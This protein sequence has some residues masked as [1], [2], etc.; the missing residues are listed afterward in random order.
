M[1]ARSNRLNYAFLLVKE[2]TRMDFKLRYHNSV[3]GYAWS[4]LKPLA[5]FTILY[6]V[7]TKIFQVG[8]AI[9]HYPVYLLSGLVVW[10]FFLEASNG[11]VTAIIE[12]GDLL[13]KLNFP[14]YVI[15]LAKTFSALINLLINCIIVTIFMI[16]FGT[17]I[18]WSALWTP[19]LLIELALFVFGVGLWMSAVY[20]K[21]RDLGYIWEVILQGLFY[22]TPILYPLQFVVLHFS[23]FAAKIILLNPV[24][25]VTQ[26]LRIGLVTPKTLTYAQVYGSNWWRLVPIS[27]VVVTLISGLFYFKNHSAEFAEHI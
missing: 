12:K 26:D 2:I 3:L 27:I 16:I 24:A 20:V 5:L 15:L 18:S 1:S 4:V 9:P 14:K 23:T 19:L 6:I 25:Q 10:N 7:F 22:A 11:S 13:R 17:T 21:F 8:N